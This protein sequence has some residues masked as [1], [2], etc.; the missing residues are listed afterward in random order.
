MK[1]FLQVVR[2]G[3]VSH[4]DLV[5]SVRT[6]M[7]PSLDP[8]L[9]NHGQNPRFQGAVLTLT[10]GQVMKPS[11]PPQHR[12]VTSKHRTHSRHLTEAWKVNTPHRHPSNQQEGFA[13]LLLKKSG[14]QRAFRINREPHDSG[15]FALVQS[16]AV[17]L[18]LIS[19]Q[20]HQPQGRSTTHTGSE[21]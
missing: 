12:G 16:L 1:F 9:R 7:F 3:N 20:R 15:S 10:V 4:T 19:A 17:C 13:F 5:I 2:D 11:P 8:Q 6:S 18:F 21:K 14:R